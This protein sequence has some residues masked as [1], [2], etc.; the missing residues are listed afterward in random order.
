MQ[1]LLSYL[2]FIYDT[3]LQLVG[4]N[5]SE[6]EKIDWI[7][8]EAVQLRCP[9]YS[10]S[11]ERALRGIILRGDIF[12][13]F[14][15]AERLAAFAKV[16]SFDFPIPS[17][18]TFFKDFG[19]LE[20]CGNS[21]KHLVPMKRRGPTVRRM[22]LQSFNPPALPAQSESPL[23]D[24]FD[25]LEAQ[26]QLAMR[27]LWL[28][29]MREFH[30]IRTDPSLL[31]RFASLAVELGFDNDE[32]RSL[33]ELSPH[34]EIARQAMALVR[35][36]QDQ[37]YNSVAD[38]AIIGQIAQAFSGHQH[39][40]KRQTYSAFTTNATTAKM[41]VRPWLDSKAYL[42]D[43]PNLVVEILDQQPLVKKKEV[44]SLFLLRSIY[45]AIFHE[46]F[47]EEGGSSGRVEPSHNQDHQYVRNH[48]TK[49]LQDHAAT[50]QADAAVNLDSTEIRTRRV[51]LQI[52]QAGTFRD[53]RYVDIHLD[54]EN[55]PN[56]IGSIIQQLMVEYRVLPFSPIGSPLLSEECYGE[57]VQK[58]HDCLYLTDD[59]RG[60]ILVQE[61]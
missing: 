15:R 26:F 55:G 12:G 31:P 8:V 10:A 40:P 34:R 50:R 48:R 46:D 59:R 2:H 41:D 21:M 58:G 17:L 23:M 4:G 49:E 18:S 43:R 53:E 5:E 14:G 16:C 13:N 25:N 7:T 1:E 24:E 32:I 54:D 22:L 42:M 57:I 51:R 6:L 52:T 11:D 56:R 19:Y 38:E 9:K 47:H 45:K 20:R 37:D 28:F 60:K 36:S 39:G 29:A 30:S 3:W 27:R 44:T 61:S 35:S 33:K